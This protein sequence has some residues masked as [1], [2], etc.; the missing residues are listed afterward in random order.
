MP[1]S[2]RLRGDGFAAFLRDPPSAL[3]HRLGDPADRSPQIPCSSPFLPAA[4]FEPAAETLLQRDVAH[5]L[6]R[7]RRPAMGKATA[8]AGRPPPPP[9]PRGRIPDPP[10]QVL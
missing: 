9:L 2:G 5:P 10:G 6:P 3:Q 8:V 7:V 4:A 1:H